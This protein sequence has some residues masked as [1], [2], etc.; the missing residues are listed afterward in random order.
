[1]V[2]RS[3]TLQQAFNEFNGRHYKPPNVRNIIFEDR[4][5]ENRFHFYIERTQNKQR[6]YDYYYYLD[7]TF[8]RFHFLFTN[9]Y[10]Y[11]NG[12]K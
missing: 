2:R 9:I 8:I 5:L 3:V 10:K 4:A 6:D 12:F 7:K 1:V 11:D